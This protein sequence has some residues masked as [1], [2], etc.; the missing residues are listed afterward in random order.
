LRG[1]AACVSIHSVPI[2][3]DASA[4]SRRFPLGKTVVHWR[5]GRAFRSAFSAVSPFELPLL[6]IEISLL[7][8][9]RPIA[10][11]EEIEVGRHGLI[12][13]RGGREAAAAAVAIEHAW[14]RETFLEHACVKAGLPRDAWRTGARICSSKRNVFSERR[15]DSAMTAADDNVCHTLV[16]ARS[17]KPA[18]AAHALRSATLMIASNLPDIDVFVFAT[19]TPS[20]AFRRGW[21]TASSRMHSFRTADGAIVLLASRSGRGRTMNRASLLCGRDSSA[22]VLHRVGLHVLMDL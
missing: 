11:I 3:A 21:T 9:E 6:E 7:T 15:D 22:A 17:A 8:P 10:S 2:C 1:D 18:Q 14:S 19:N 5:S 20:V 12:V 16:G 13:E 4:V